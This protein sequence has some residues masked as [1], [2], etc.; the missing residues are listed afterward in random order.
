[1]QPLPLCEVDPVLDARLEVALTHLATSSFNENLETAQQR[2]LECGL[3]PTTEL[4]SSTAQLAVANRIIQLMY[5]EQRPLLDIE[6]E[7]WIDVPR[8]DA[9]YVLAANHFNVDVYVF[10]TNKYPR[11]F[12][13]AG[14]AIHAV[15]I[16]EAVNTFDKT[17]ALIAI[18]P[19][20]TPRR[21]NP[22]PSKKLL[23]LLFF[24]SS[25]QRHFVTRLVQ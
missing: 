19:S 22:C 25:Q 15:G 5:A 10:S 9:I 18:G 1:M 8:S 4:A 6:K 14:S 16:F 20:R 7:M 21:R 2:F 17:S 11:M 12:R 24:Q 3:I 13:S 23:L